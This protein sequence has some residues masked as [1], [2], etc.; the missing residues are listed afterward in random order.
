MNE[1]KCV[2]CGRKID[3]YDHWDVNGHIFCDSP[4]SIRFRMGNNDKCSNCGKKIFGSVLE[5]QNIETG[6]YFIFVMKNVSINIIKE[7]IIN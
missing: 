7:I 6:A 1:E 5:A 4:C 2:F 3:L